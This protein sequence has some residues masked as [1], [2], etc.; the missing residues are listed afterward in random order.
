MGRSGYETSVFAVATCSLDIKT[1][2]G[3]Q[4]LLKLKM[5]EYCAMNENLLVSS[6]EGKNP[7]L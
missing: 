5:I 4:V 7:E 1:I 2:T 3:V 6:L